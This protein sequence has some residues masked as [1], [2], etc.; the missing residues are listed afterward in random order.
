MGIPSPTD[1]PIVE[2]V[3]SA[4]KRVFGACVLNRK[5]LISPT[6]IHDIVKKA[7]LENPV[8]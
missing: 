8:V 3:G 4:S 1:I 2:A 6:L 5:E 7:D